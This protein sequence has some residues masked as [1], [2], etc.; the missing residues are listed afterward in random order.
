MAGTVYSVG[1][2]NTYIS[3]LFEDSPLLAS[4]M[5]KGEVSNCRYAVRGD[6]SREFLKNHGIIWKVLREA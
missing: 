2:V 5:V 1:Q 6:L 4:I 3:R